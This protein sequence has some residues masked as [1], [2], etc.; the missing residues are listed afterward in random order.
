MGTMVMMISI[1][2]VLW[3]GLCGMPEVVAIVDVVPNVEV[4]VGTSG[5]VSVNNVPVIPTPDFKVITENGVTEV[6]NDISIN[7]T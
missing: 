4:W 3:S 1:L 5:K 6:V 7:I 2:C